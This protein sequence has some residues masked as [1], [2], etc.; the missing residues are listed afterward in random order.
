MV[1]AHSGAE[2]NSTVRYAYYSYMVDGTRYEGK[3]RVFLP[4][5]YRAG[6]SFS[7]YYD[8]SHPE[9]VF[10]RFAAEISILGLLF[11]LLFLIVI[12]AAIRQKSK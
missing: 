7:V 8:P 1:Y 10:D 5:I 3:V 9:N 4:F 11:I 12:L 6:K 2:S